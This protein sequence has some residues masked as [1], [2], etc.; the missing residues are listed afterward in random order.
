MIVN[1]YLVIIYEYDPYYLAILL[2][3]S[4]KWG[5]NVYLFKKKFLMK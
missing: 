5:H 3:G 1:N 4:I 2:I